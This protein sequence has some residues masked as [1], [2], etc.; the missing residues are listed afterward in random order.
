MCINAVLQHCS[1]LTCPYMCLGFMQHAAGAGV[2][3]LPAA[4]L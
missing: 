2:V 4:G 3:E 1:G